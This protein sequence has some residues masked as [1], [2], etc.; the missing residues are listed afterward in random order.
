[1]LDWFSR[2]RR[3]AGM[4]A[5]GVEP[6]ATKFV[7]VQRSGGGRPLATLWTNVPSTESDQAQVIQRTVKEHRL[8]GCAR[9]TLLEPADYQILLVE[10]PK[11]PP[12]ELKA[13]IRWRI[14]DLLEYHVDDATVDVFELRSGSEAA[15][16]MYAVA[17]PNQVVQK[18][19]ALFAEADVGLKV[20]DIPDM[21]QRNVAALFE[22]PDKATAMLA[23]SSWGGLLTISFQGE[24]L[25]TRRLE[26]TAVQLGQR[27]HGDHYR[28]RVATEMTRSLDM[29]ERQR[30]SVGVGELILAPLPQDP[31]LEQF[32]QSN[33][34]VPVR[35]TALAEVMDFAGGSEP[36]LDE[37]WEYFHLF[38]A[39]LRVEEKTL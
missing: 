31:G 15:K 30:L 26:V 28:E 6:D 7:H 2:P 38:G 32:L 17:A 14:K 19:I 36:P 24:L 18:R 13:A 11:V 4:L 5:V 27:E 12:E 22:S 3:V 39:A 35:S 9:T 34:Y 29:F 25:L 37:Q 33:L 16:A 21:A 10:P 20:I 1:L 23:F 8:G